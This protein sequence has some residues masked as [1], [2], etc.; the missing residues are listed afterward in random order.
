MHNKTGSII[1]TTTL[2]LLL[3]TS[4][5]TAKEETPVVPGL[6]LLSTEVLNL[7]HPSCECESGM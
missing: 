7:R 3:I 5:L 1:V 2:G 6:S 4:V